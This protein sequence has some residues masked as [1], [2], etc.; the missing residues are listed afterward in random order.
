MLP[1]AITSILP[2]STHLLSAIQFLKFSILLQNCVVHLSKQPYGFPILKHQKKINPQKYTIFIRENW[3][4]V[5]RKI[6]SILH[7]FWHN[8]FYKSHTADN[9]IW[10]INHRYYFLTCC[11]L[12]ETYRK[13]YMIYTNKYTY[14]INDLHKI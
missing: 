10:D 11:L 3:I 8:Y 7:N 13:R 4:C 9:K 6:K 1:S 5:T 2:S 12:Q 14:M